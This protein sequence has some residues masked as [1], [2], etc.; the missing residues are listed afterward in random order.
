MLRNFNPATPFD[1]MCREAARLGYKGFDT[2]LPE[3]WP[4]LRKYGLVPALV[5]STATPVPFTDGIVTKALHDKMEAL[6]HADLDQAAA[7]GCSTVGVA[8]GQ[9]RGLSYEQGMDNCVALLNRVKAHAEDKAVNICIEVQSRHDRPDQICDHVAWAVEMCKRV[10]SP[11]VKVLFDCYHIQIMDGD[12]VRNIRDHIA[13]ICHFHVGGLNGRREIDATQ[14]LNYRFVAKAIAD[15]G[16]TGY[17]GH[18]WTPS[19]GHDPL[20]ALAEAFATIDV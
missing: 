1:D 15:L 18:E 7:G 8:G 17:I 13:W 10:N 9:R 20:K 4:T 12:I 5:L 3:N 2:I 16:F 14:E 19:P 6:I 11:R